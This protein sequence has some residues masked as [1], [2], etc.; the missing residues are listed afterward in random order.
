MTARHDMAQ[1][2][3][4]IKVN[5]GGDVQHD[6]NSWRPGDTSLVGKKKVYIWW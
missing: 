3:K 1:L 5:D 2:L 4:H 6:V